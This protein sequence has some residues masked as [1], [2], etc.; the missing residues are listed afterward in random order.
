LKTTVMIS[1]LIFAFHIPMS[2]GEGFESFS[3]R[4]SL[5]QQVRLCDMAG[6]ST[7][8]EGGLSS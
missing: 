7:M 8:V 5:A 3:I 2:N 1:A 4:T 6:I